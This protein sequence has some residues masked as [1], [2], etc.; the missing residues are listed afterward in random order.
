MA[1]VD[2]IQ[3]DDIKPYI[4]VRKDNR[5]ALPGSAHPI[6]WFQASQALYI[7]PMKLQNLNFA[8]AIY[9]LETALFTKS[10]MQMPRWVFYDCAVMPGIVVGYAMHR[11][12]LTE[13]MRKCIKPNK[14]LEWV[15]LSMFIAIP[16][17]SAG[18]W[19]AHN[20]C[21][22]NSVLPKKKQLRSLGF[23]SKAFGLWYANIQN[24]HGMTQWDSPA[25]KLHSLFGHLE[26]FAAYSPIHTYAS[27]LTYR[28]WV[29]SKLWYRFFSKTGSVEFDEFFEKSDIVIDPK[30]EETMKVLQKKIERQTGPFYLSGQE[31]AKNPL[32]SPLRVFK[33][34]KH[35]RQKINF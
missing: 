7:D 6:D 19:V 1:I 26:I 20:L 16:T 18:Q 23:L 11:D 3:R 5:S 32:G 25:L 9:N 31:I 15:P 4:F 8:E 33:L 21:S 29:D 27:T 14:D 24:L 35:L 13:E 2:W 34:R 28:T 17:N 10:S 12:S 22:I 30:D